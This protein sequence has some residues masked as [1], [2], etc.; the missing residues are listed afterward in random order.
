MPYL[1]DF[2]RG[3]I[4]VDGVEVTTIAS[5]LW[6]RLITPIDNEITA[7]Y[8]FKDLFAKHASNG[9]QIELH[10]VKTYPS[11]CT[12]SQRLNA[13]IALHVMT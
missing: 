6:T 10:L 8:L 13:I 5:I 11:K 2:Q 7:F 12:I 3:I 1:R 9:K 4:A